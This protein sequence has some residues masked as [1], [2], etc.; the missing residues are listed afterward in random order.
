MSARNDEQELRRLAEASVWCMR[1]AEADDQT[2]MAFEVWLASDP[3]NAAAWREVE[4]PWLIV[5]NAATSP[6]LATA[7]ADA[8]SNARRQKRRRSTRSGVLV[9]VLSSL[10]AGLVLVAVLFAAGDPLLLGHAFRTERGER[11]VVT[12]ED[13]SRLSLDASSLVRVRYTAEARRLELVRGQVRFDVAHDVRR[14]FSVQARDQTVI[15]TGTAFN[16]DLLGSK[17]LVTLIQGHVTVLKD[18]RTG[19]RLL[20]ARS[21]DR[22]KARPPVFVLNPGQQLVATQGGPA[23]VELASIDRATAWET[24]RLLFEDEALPA[25]AERVSRY[26]EYPIIVDPSARDLRISGV[27]NVGDVPNFVDAVT[28][29]L[30]IEAADAKDGAIVLRRKRLVK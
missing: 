23:H 2:V 17:V 20:P 19:L 30:P 14:P 28:H 22:S 1:L 29:Y 25:V 16:I 10:A 18:E 7:R 6:E 27:F 5:G 15:A 9:K 12:L 24:G 21:L 26:S 11:R 13:G 3:D 4:M 8:L